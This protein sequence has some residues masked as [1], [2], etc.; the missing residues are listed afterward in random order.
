MIFWSF[1]F[2]WSKI[3]L[4][5]YQPV[6]IILIRLIISSLI[7]V[8]SLMLFKKLQKLKM[9]DLKFFI[10]LSFLQPFIYFLGESYGLQKVSPTTAS[11]II[12]TIPLFSPIAAFYV[13]KEKF[14]WLY[15]A[16]IILSIIG[17]LFVISGKNISFSES[18]AGI[19]L[20]FLAVSAAVGYSVVLKKISVE[21]NAFSI[22]T[23]Q[24]IF[25]TVFFLPLFF[26]LDWNSFSTAHHNFAATSS[27]ILLAIF[28]SSFAYIFYTYSVQ[29]IG[30]NKSIIFCNIIPVFTMIFSF[31]VVGEEITGMKIIGV[32]IVIAGLLIS[33]LQGFKKTKEIEVII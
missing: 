30:V 19:A 31:F 10:M 18:P 17:I 5:T 11:V 7:L 8:V 6:T 16:G 21:Y 20:L 2:V 27:I 23:Y 26:I 25:G 12:S 24:N 1:S 33:Q 29:K 4:Q 15:F 32:I 22:T 14:T 9:H 3:A 28:G 13:I